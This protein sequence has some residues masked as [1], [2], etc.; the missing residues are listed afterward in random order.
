M[1][2]M[3]ILHLTA[4]VPYAP[5][6]T[7]GAT[8][9]FHLLRRLVELGHDVTVVAPV[10]P[11]QESAVGALAGAGIG[12]RAC[13]RPAHREVEAARVLARRP[14]LA[15][16]AVSLPVLA[17][18]AAILWDRLRPVA[19]RA[20]DARR[21][22]VVHVEHDHSA[23]WLAGL[24]SPPAVLSLDNVSW[25]YYRSRA[26]AARGAAR[27]ALLAEAERF[28]RYDARHLGRY[29]ALV[30]VSER[31]RAELLRRGAGRVELVPNGVD[32]DEL[33]P[34]PPSG[35]PPT[36]LFTGSMDHPPNGEGVRW[37]AEQA[38]PEVRRRV[39]G[40]RLLVVGR[41]PP[42]AVRA[43]AR[44]PSIEVT[45]GV[46]SVAPF[47]H[48]ASAVVIPLRSGGGT[49]LKALEAMAAGRAI[50]S[51]SIGVEG[52]EV[53]DGHDVLLRDDAA[54]FAEGAVRLLEDEALARRLAAAGREVVASRYD[55]R[56]LGDR[57][58]AVLLE[59]AG[60]SGPTATPRP[61]VTARR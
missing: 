52:L 14:A 10:H 35:E 55:W 29:A 37:F 23:G 61:A 30:A 7:G 36:L 3:R 1:A 53:R 31:D 58:E 45:G 17:L 27:L 40:V 48:R 54:S 46:P 5:G 57:L 47:F 59:A 38:W 56:A 9:Q 51:T 8:R 60:R 16:R 26:R 50:V 6:G 28:R 41:N 33:A 21:P 24:E 34:T 22:D 32:L 43:L 13:R 12:L 19:E 15:S 20:L 2:A 44:D 18:Q 39:P 42:A 25:D 49:R 11:D 4:E